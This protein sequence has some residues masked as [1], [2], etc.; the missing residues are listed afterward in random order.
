MT[1]QQTAP[2]ATYQTLPKPGQF[3]REVLH[4]WVMIAR[5]LASWWHVR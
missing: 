3:T 4:E 2:P 1:T 5:E